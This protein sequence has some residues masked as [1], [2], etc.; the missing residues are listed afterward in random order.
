MA[1]KEIKQ[2]A[3]PTADG[4]AVFDG[5]KYVKSVNNLTPDPNTGSVYIS[6]VDSATV[7]KS[8]R[9]I[10]G[11][12][13]NGSAN[14]TT[15]YWGTARNIAISDYLS[16]NTGPETSVNGSSNVVLKLPATIKANINGNCTG[17]SGSC[18]GNSATATNAINA[19]HATTA[20][21]ATNATNASHATLADRA[22]NATNATNANHAT[23]ATKATQDGAGQQINTTYVKGVTTSNATITVTK[24]NGTTSTATINNVANAT[25][26]TYATNATKAMNDGNGAN[27]A[28]TY[29]KL[30]TAQT[31]TAQ[32]NF[33]SGIKINGITVT[34]E[35]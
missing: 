11:T 4:T 34:V 2:L 9:N 7:L 32:H 30:A 8:Y 3:F 17:S 27:I 22:T 33:S 28:N 10:N 15:Q 21:S 14:I 25:N 23:T 29:V 20:D 19:N 18:T 12:P 1:T 35:V 5:T 26:A 16:T 31:I 13:F 6:N 24:G